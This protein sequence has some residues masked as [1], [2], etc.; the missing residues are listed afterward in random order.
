MKKFLT[1]VRIGLLKLFFTFAEAIGLFALF[2]KYYFDTSLTARSKMG[3]LPVIMREKVDESYILAA[4][5]SIREN[6]EVPGAV[7]LSD[8][9]GT[10]VHKW[11]TVY[12]ASNARLTRDGE[13]YVSL[14]AP[15]RR[16]VSGF[17]GGGRTG[18]I[19]K[20]DWDSTVL[21]EYKDPK[22]H[23]DFEVLPNGNVLL[24][25]WDKLSNEQ[26]REVAS[27]VTGR[28]SDAPLWSDVVF[29][30]NN[31]GET[32]WEWHAKDHVDPAID[33]MGQFPYRDE[34]THTNSATLVEK[35][36]FDGESAILLSM[37]HTGRL[38]MVSKRTGAVLWRSPKNMFLGQ[39]S[40]S[41]LQNGNIMAFDNGLH[42]LPSS[43]SEVVSS[44]VLQVNPLT[45][46]IVWSLDGGKSPL[47][48][49]RL[50]SSV[51]CGAER[52]RNGNI[53]VSV[54]PAGH[55]FEVTP[56]KE[57]VWDYINPFTAYASGI[58]PNNGVFLARRYHKDE[59]VW[60]ET[61]PSPL[62]A[63][64]AYAQIAIQAAKDSL[65]Q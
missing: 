8:L 21:W 39:H 5:F 64:P 23:H 63:R 14:I 17:P 30:V 28:S 53:H 50:Y 48:K 43:H 38:L 26:T 6:N 62:P 31:R 19:Q 4:P 56:E 52:L 3:K 12:Q 32:V 42:R 41:F 61:L 34:W 2:E 40:P 13:L 27:R 1:Y 44:R 15:D 20:L 10:C 55:F 35:S 25:G 49:A 59:I 18:I 24:I 60:P 46:E 11:K 58:W 33:E 22:I 37:R 9:Y 45:D 54:G 65:N 51:V 57:L 16:D 7:Y 29:E 36:P 47:E